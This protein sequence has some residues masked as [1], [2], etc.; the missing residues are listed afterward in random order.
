MKHH[1]QGTLEFPHK[2]GEETDLDLVRADGTFEDDQ[3][4]EKWAQCHNGINYDGSFL[5]NRHDNFLKVK[6]HGKNQWNCC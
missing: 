1:N 5:Y 2:P 4:I 6:E 3:L